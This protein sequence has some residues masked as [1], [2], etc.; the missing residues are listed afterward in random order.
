MQL[1]LPKNF[2]QLLIKHIA[3]EVTQTTVEIMDNK[4]TN[5]MEILQTVNKH[6]IEKMNHLNTIV[7]LMLD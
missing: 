4:Q 7:Y 1:Y 6:V 2:V 5:A 3:C